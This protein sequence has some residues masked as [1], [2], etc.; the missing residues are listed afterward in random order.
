M[1]KTAALRQVHFI[2]APP[3][4]VHAAYVDAKK[5]AMFTGSKATMDTTVG[6]AIEL[7]VAYGSLCSLCLVFLE[8]LR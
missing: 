6:G 8:A 7:F 3:K 4:K 1:A 2:A 5:H